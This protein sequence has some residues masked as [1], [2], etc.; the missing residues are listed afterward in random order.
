[1]RVNRC[2]VLLLAAVLLW[3]G[4]A[5][6]ASRTGKNLNRV[7]TWNKITDYFATIGKSDREKQNI[8]R[9]RKVR[10]RTRRL[11]KSQRKAEEERRRRAGQYRSS[12]ISQ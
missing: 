11:K 12:Y 3:N 5:H 10:R 4:S 1:M 7:T 8:L 9:K 2:L 6:A